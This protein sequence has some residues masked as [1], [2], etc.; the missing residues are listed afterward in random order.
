MPAAARSDCLY[1]PQSAGEEEE[2]EEELL[3]V[4]VVFSFSIGLRSSCGLLMLV[5][6]VG[7]SCHL[8]PSL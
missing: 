3:A 7:P 5:V 1:G 2:E 6:S 4:V 8:M